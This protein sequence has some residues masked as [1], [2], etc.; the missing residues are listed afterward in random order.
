MA[1]VAALVVLQV[2]L[3]GAEKQSG[4]DMAAAAIASPESRGDR[5]ATP[6][7]SD[8]QPTPSTRA[9]AR[10]GSSNVSCP[11]GLDGVAG[12]DAA[13]ADGAFDAPVRVAWGRRRRGLGR[14]RRR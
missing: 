13:E 3:L 11:A 4:A 12:G 9:R 7:S 5:H 14:E 6:P 10:K 1:T 8:L 2:L